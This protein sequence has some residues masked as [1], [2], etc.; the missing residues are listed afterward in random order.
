MD[1]DK[2]LFLIL[3]SDLRDRNVANEDFVRLV[4]HTLSF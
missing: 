1:L 3:K 2:N 4:L